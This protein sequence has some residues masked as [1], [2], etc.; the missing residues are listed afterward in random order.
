[1]LNNW[2]VA[3][4]ILIVNVDLELL[5]NSISSWSLGIWNKLK[6]PPSRSQTILLWDLKWTQMILPRWIS[7]EL[8]RSSLQISNELK[9]SFL[10]I[11]NK[12]KWS[13]LCAKC[14]NLALNHDSDSSPICTRSISNSRI[15]QI[16]FHHCA[17][18]A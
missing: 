7:N 10:E 5:T 8:K 11:S 12:L 15:H 17:Q 6:D 18:N 16:C 4:K 14:W 13:P 3:V 2:I 9:G 1:M